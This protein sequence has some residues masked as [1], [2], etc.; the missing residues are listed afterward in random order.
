MKSPT[1]LYKC[2]G[3]H[4]IHGGHFDYTI[5]DEGDIE[6]ALAEGWHLTTTDAKAEHDAASASGKPV[7][8]D[9][10]PATRDELKQKADELGLT[11]PGNISNAKLAELVEQA[12][13]K[14]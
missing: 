13:A 10:A 12:L 5:V 3:P 9:S 2:P 4:Q 7:G 1:M 11:Y 6:Q 14:A 8:D